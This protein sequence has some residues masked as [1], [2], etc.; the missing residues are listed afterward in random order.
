MNSNLPLNLNEE[1][2]SP[3]RGKRSPFRFIIW[4]VL[5]VMA[6]F[7]PTTIKLL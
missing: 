7:A 5:I 2:L 1:A 6:V 4:A 3:V